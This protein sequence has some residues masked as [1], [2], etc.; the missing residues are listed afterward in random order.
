M[1]L[2][3]LST[4][5]IGCA[6]AIAFATPAVAATPHVTVQ[7]ATTT[8]GNFSVSYNKSW[9]FKSKPEGVCLGLT[10]TG[11]IS[12]T[13]QISPAGHGVEYDWTNIKVHSPKLAASVQTY[14]G[15]SCIGPATTTKVTIAQHWAG[16]SCGF[17]P[18][19]SAALPWGVGV[20]AW[21]SCSSRSQAKY[22]TTYSVRSAS[23]TQNNT[24][25]P[26]SYGT[27]VRLTEP[28][29]PCYGV[30][31][32]AVVYQGNSS[33]SYGAGSGSSSREVCLSKN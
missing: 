1:T 15:G 11:S 10:A 18:A 26:V 30:F 8:I 31:V 4:V 22:S 24:G 32:S 19:I 16:Y 23:Y 7:P 17:D 3:R 12:Y 6:A 28:K 21:P 9:T 27:E 14:G 2:R 20:S 33:D 25:S 29:Y 5:F 13:L